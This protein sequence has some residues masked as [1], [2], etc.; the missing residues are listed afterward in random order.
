[1]RGCHVLRPADDRQWA[2]NPMRQT[3][4][5]QITWEEVDLNTHN[6]VLP[7]YFGV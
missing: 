7:G 4:V 3:N 5:G 1:M 2:C 6:G